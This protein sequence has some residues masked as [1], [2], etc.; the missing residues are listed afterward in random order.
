MVDL[1][2]DGVWLDDGTLVGLVVLR[3][4]ALEVLP[5][6]EPDD[7]I[8]AIGRVE[9]LADGPAVVVDD[10][11]GIIRAGD[12]VAEAIAQTGG[13]A[14]TQPS[15]R[16]ADQP[17]ESVPPRL[18]AIADASGIGAGLAGLGTLIALSV[19]SLAFTV[20]RTVHARRR[21]EA[22]IAARVAEFAAPAGLPP[23]PRSDEHD[24][25]PFHS[26]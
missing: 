4:P 1:R 20:G 8:N 3:G 26:A 6:L 13:A 22:R 24:R 15:G 14:G 12:P 18:A 25:R 10:P 7:A 21:A 5:L 11:A 16:A 9:V 23:R 19:I 17:F 2:V